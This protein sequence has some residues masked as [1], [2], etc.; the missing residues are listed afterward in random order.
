MRAFRQLLGYECELHIAPATGDTTIMPLVALLISQGLHFKVVVDTTVHGK[1]SKDKLQEGYGIPD[2][3]ISEVEIPTGFPQ[4]KGSGIEDAFSKTDF[5]KLLTSTGNTPGADFET[6]SNSQYMKKPGV[7]P[8]R[9]V[10]H[11]FNKHVTKYYKDEFDEETL[12][13]M[14][15]IIDFCMNDDWFLLL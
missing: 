14:R 15:R 3:S 4:A 2:T 11:E 6:L 7:V 12:T 8:K 13:N 9:V 1:S 5:S 10:A